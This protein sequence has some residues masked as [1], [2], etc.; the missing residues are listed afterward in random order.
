M[1]IVTILIWSMK[2]KIHLIVE[3][4]YFHDYIN[5]RIVTH[6]DLYISRISIFLIIEIKS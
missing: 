5:F 3:I 1:P 2:V 6:P 4:C